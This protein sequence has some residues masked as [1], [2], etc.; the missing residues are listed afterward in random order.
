MRERPNP[1]ETDSQEE[2][3]PGLAEELADTAD[4]GVDP[5]LIGATSVRT[6]SD[7]YSESPNLIP[8]RDADTEAKEEEGVAIVD[9]R[10][11]KP[12]AAE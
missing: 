11:T 6:G 8:T 1:E 4:S 7:S 5:T 2:Y 12:E 3:E 10:V 9:Y